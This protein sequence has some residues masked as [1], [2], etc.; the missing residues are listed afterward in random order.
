MSGV[1]FVRNHFLLVHILQCVKHI[2]SILG[3]SLQHVHVS[4]DSGLISARCFLQG[5]YT[6][7]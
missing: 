3:T 2:I 7:G 4:H 1:T 6:Q 5:I